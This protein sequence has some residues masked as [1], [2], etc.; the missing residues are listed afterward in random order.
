MSQSEAREPS[1]HGHQQ[2]GWIE[3]FVRRPV[4]ATVLNL[5]LIIAGIAALRVVEIRELPDV[6]NPVVTVRTTYTGATPESVDSQI[7]AIIESA[8]SRVQGVRSISSNSSYGSSRVV[9]ELSNRTNLDTAASDVRDAV[10]AIRNQLPR[11]LEDEPRVVKADSDASPIIRMAVTSSTL[12]EGEL[13]DLV[14]NVIE[15]R[16]AAVEGVADANSYGLRKKT[17]EVRVSPVA[18]AARGLSLAD[19]MTAIGNA[20]V[21]SPSGALENATQQILV[22]SEAPISTPEQVG[23]LELNPATKVSD[24]AFV[25]WAFETPTAL[26]RL[27]GT[28]AIGVEIIRQA[29]SNTIAISDGIRDAVVELKQSLPAGVDV[30]VTSDDATFIRGSIREVVISLR[31]RSS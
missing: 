12:S 16:L 18:L 13:T 9:I 20:A 14:E 4:L 3:T 11:D 17:I 21:T 23:A 24:V 26:T 30:T 25:R 7:T 29:Q 5:L 19:L 10:A 6:D 28:T 15:D 1:G 8:V 31:R 27:N 22:R 2:G